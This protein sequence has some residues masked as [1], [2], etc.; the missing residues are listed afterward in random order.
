MQQN[1]VEKPQLG[2]EEDAQT[3]QTDGKQAASSQTQVNRLEPEQSG[4]IQPAAD[5]T[6]PKESE[7]KPAQVLQAVGEHQGKHSEQTEGNQ[8]AE[9]DA[10]ATQV[11]AS[12]VRDKDVDAQEEVQLQKHTVQVDDDGEDDVQDQQQLL[13]D[14]ENQCVS[15]GRHP[16]EWDNIKLQW[17]DEV[18]CCSL[19]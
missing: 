8:L 2:T 4:P 1:T 11:V 10:Q 7:G 14:I 19:P 13:K 5:Q 12:Q 16:G 18:R 17:E 9:K 15:H 3:E 6:D